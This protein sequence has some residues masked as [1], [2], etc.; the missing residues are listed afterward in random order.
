[1]RRNEGMHLGIVSETHWT[2][3]SCHGKPHFGP[4]TQQGQQATTA[5]RFAMT[6]LLHIANSRPNPE[7]SP[8]ACPPSGPPSQPPDDCPQPPPSAPPPHPPP[9]CARWPASFSPFPEEAHRCQHHPP[10]L[11]NAPPAL[12]NAPLQIANSRPRPDPSASPLC[13]ASWAYT[14][15][16]WQMATGKIRQE[17]SECSGQ[18]GDRQCYTISTKLH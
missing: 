13:H 12:P 8:F 18:N 15:D 10:A 9:G 4:A 17:K 14:C 11:P 7:P 3:T 16:T 2:P 6:Q 5:G 1:M